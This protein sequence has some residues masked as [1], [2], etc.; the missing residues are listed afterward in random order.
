MKMYEKSIR[1]PDKMRTMQYAFALFCDL[2]HGL[3]QIVQ[4]DMG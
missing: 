4:D 1:L 2:H 3:K